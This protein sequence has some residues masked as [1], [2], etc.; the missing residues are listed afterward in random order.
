M[1]E[2]CDAILLDLGL[3]DIDGHEVCRLLWH[4]GVKSPIIMKPDFKQGR[5]SS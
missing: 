4:N 5:I 1:G 3:P 2:H